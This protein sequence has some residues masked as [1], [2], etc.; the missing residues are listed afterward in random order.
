LRTAFFG[1]PP[2]AVPS[3]RSLVEGGL[4]PLGLVT[5][6]ARRAGRGRKEI[7]NELVTIAEGA[8][9]PVLRPE[10]A[11]D[12]GFLAAFAEWGAELGVVVAYGQI[13]RRRLL[14]IPSEGFINLHGSLLP[15]WRGAS[16]VQAAILAGDAVSGVSIQRVV[17]ALDA[18]AVLSERSVAL[19]PTERGDELFERLSRVGAQA[20]L[21]FLSGL[22]G[23]SLA[24]GKEQD[25]TAVTICRKIRRLNGEIDW[26]R[27]SEEIDRLV[28]AMYGWPWAQSC[29]PGGAAV[30][31]LAGEPFSEEV[32]AQSADPAPPGTVLATEGGL[33]VACGKGRYRIDRLQRT[34]KAALAS[35]EFLRGTPIEIGARLAPPS[36]ASA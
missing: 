30:R 25:E 27:S 16:P 4:A 23:S 12:A 24:A 13:L 3:F 21:E 36:Q 29:L 6:P 31:V 9:I 7:E 22:H 20:L 10:R 5:A 28:R 2:F 33:V 17:E 32:G 15:R 14:D 8:G 1:S 11:D 34:G 19:S 26:S 35:D 18:G